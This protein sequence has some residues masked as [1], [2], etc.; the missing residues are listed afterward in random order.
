M[1]NITED[2]YKMALK[3]VKILKDAR[4]K[5]IERAVREIANMTAFSGNISEEIILQTIQEIEE[6]QGIKMPSASMVSGNQK[7]TEWL[8]TERIEE[9]KRNAT[10]NYSEDY[11]DYLAETEKFPPEVIS[12]IDDA[13]NR[14][15]EKCGD[16]QNKASW[17][18][19]GMVVGSVQSGKTANYV[20]L[21]NK[22]ADFGY[23]III[24]IT[25][26]HENLRSQTQTRIDKGFIG[27]AIDTKTWKGEKIGVGEDYRLCNIYPHAFTSKFND[28]AIKIASTSPYKIDSKCE[29]P[30]IF[31]IKKNPN[32]L[33]N[34]IRYFESSPAKDLSNKINHPMLLIDDEADNASINTA[35][36]R[37]AITKINSQIR[38]ILN[39][40][41]QA[42]YVGYTATPFAN[43]F[44]D[45]DSQ[46]LIYSYKQ[47]KENKEYEIKTEEL[48]SRDLFPRDFIVGLE[49]PDN[50]FGPKVIFGEEGKFEEAVIE[51]Y[52]NEDYITLDPKIHNKYF[53]PDVPPSLK[54]AVICFFISDAI[55]NIRGLFKKKDSSMM[56]NVSRFTDVQNKLK[57]KIKDIVKSIKRRITT[58]SGLDSSLRKEGLKEIEDIFNKYYGDLNLDWEKV[59]SS[60]LETYSRVKIMEINQRSTDVLKYKDEDDEQDPVS[61]VVIGGF[62]LSRGITLKGL[63]ISYILRNSLMYDTL[64]QMG[65]WFGYRQGYEDICRM[66]MTGNMKDDFEHITNSV[67]EL[68]QDLKSLEKSKSTPFD[69]GLRVLS[70]PDSLMITARNKEGKSKIIKTTFDFS[71]K[72]IETFSVPKN[73]KVILNNYKLSENLIEKCFTLKSN[74]NLDIIKNKYNGYFFEN[75]NADIVVNYLTN[76]VAAS[77][78]NQL[79]VIDPIIKYILKRQDNNEL[80]NWDIYIPSPKDKIETRGKGKF[81]IERREFEIFEQKFFASHRAKREDDDFS[82]KLT[83]KSKVADK[84]I[85]KI[86]LSKEKISVLENE[87]GENAN[88]KPK[89]LNCFGRKPLLVIHLF[90]LIK[91]KED[92]LEIQPERFKVNIPENIS[93]AA[94]SIV[95]PGSNIEEEEEE[96]RVN[97][98]YSRQFDMSE[99]EMSET[100]A[101][102]DSDLNI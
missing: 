100:E 82:F 6:S 20:S 22:A 79:K 97:E 58:Y 28:F 101:N 5:D 37:G 89:I 67:L 102:D 96:Y 92:G 41:S 46:K 8:T 84:T 94:W 57:H 78:S 38:K 30:L 33:E 54:E 42:S 83:L 26:I 90:D 64:L 52:D 14:I 77:Y 31:T 29:R 68:M 91:D 70:H 86:G 44:I 49:P 73:Q 19:R 4:E 55:K 34:L 35:Y 61:Y 99:K 72:L 17:E 24:V 53:E 66:W 76:F 71:G 63:T 50:Y 16:P 85:A 62:S 13:T 87:S 56:I 40:F 59:N 32:V 7:F 21:I 9:C 18:R 25:G 65:R 27:Y 69:F 81:K 51:I 23:K 3:N 10:L 11:E 75:I 15:L 36:K 47:K 2:F 80:S 45:P 95:F 88:Q 1:R 39:L 43:I 48:N 98:I 93:I 12:K 74:E 60:L